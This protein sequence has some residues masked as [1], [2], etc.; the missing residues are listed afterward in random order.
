MR[1]LRDWCDL[2]RRLRPGRK[3]RL[4]I[5]DEIVFHIEE[6]VEGLVESGIPESEARARVLR[7]FG[8]IQG[9][10]DRM[11]A[12]AGTRV[13]RQ[14]RE[15]VMDG[16]WRD[17]KLTARGLARRP[18]FSGV[19]IL[20][21]ALGIGANTAVFS[22]LDSILLRPLPFHEPD[23][24]VR[25]YEE[26]HV[27]DGERVFPNGYLTVPAFFDLREA[28]HLFQEVAAFSA[29]REFGSDL[30]GG[31]RPE[32]V[33]RMPVSS[34]FFHVLGISPQLGRSFTIA[35]ERQGV[36]LA[37]IS[38][39]LWQRHFAGV[40]DV[41]GASLELDGEVFEVIGVMPQGFRG[42]LGR[43]VEVW[44]PA[45]LDP[46]NE[47]NDRGNHFLSAVGRLAPGVTFD[48]VRW[49]IEAYSRSIA[50]EEGRIYDGAYWTTVAIP[51]HE[52]TVGGTRAT[53]WVLMAAVA[54]VLLST[55]V[56][57]ANLFLVR[58]FSRT[59]ELAIRASLGC[60]RGGLIRVLLNE[61]MLLSLLGGGFGLILAWAG[62]QG[63]VRLGPEGLPR[64]GEIGLDPSVLLF[65][66]TVSMAT[67]L[68]LG[69]TPILRASSQDLTRDLR[70]MGR[71]GTG[72]R[73]Y[74]RLRSALVVAEVAVALVLLVGAATLIRSFQ[75]I[76]AVDLK[77]ETEGILTYEV[78]LPTSRYPDGQ[79]REAFYRDFFPRV[80]SLTGVEAVGAISWLPVNGGYNN[81]SVTR[82]DVA[83]DSDYRGMQA[84]IRVVA[85][86]Y[87][88]A[89][90]VDLVSGRY[91]DDKDDPGNRNAV[92]VNELFRDQLFQGEEVLGKLIRVGGQE[93][94][95]VGVVENVPQDAFGET[96][97]KLY[98]PHAQ[99]ADDRNW[100]LTQTLSCRGDQGSLISR[101][102]EE[103]DAVDPNLVLFRVRPLETVL[104][105][106]LVQ[107]RFS[108]LLME[109]F[110][111]LA[112][113]LA[114]VGIYGVLSYLVSQRKHEIGVRIALGAGAGAVR[115]MV[116]KQGLVLSGIGVVLGLGSALYLS[117]WLQVLV[118]EIEV[119]E[120]WMF[121]AVA[122][123]LGGVAGAAS[124]LPARQATRVDPASAFR[125][126]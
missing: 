120:P 89:L 4:D 113:L 39:G 38:H 48:Q 50:E 117:R 114:T 80:A 37:V 26:V 121:C 43:A 3:A 107:Q 98:L 20:T 7:D 70:E 52:D 58:S 31:E 83:E 53:L 126:E 32:R 54:L 69:L 15:D 122:L 67:G 36:G 68:V 81:W 93:W 123:G 49:G 19:V 44:T 47:N 108:L 22:V 35:E 18:G 16:V 27:P 10:R 73:S 12:M 57:V 103:L 29:Y 88:E 110:A 61:T 64:V 1:P 101:L 86:D 95:V 17:I 85:G 79:S 11:S 60:G 78:H 21:L 115:R 41:L 33:V 9:A 63:L 45:S 2:W 91:L 46:A 34:E 119:V 71:T 42:P 97:P 124:Y 24:L 55:C 106:A 28:S 90:A 6:E 104:G 125:E 66:L 84:D 118:F 92:V 30:T 102:R 112:L 25:I 99:F 75:A 77:V 105:A 76:R 62:V 82:P 87:F 8:D 14:R 116:M 56:N 111:G 100:P 65:T 23:R 51:L 109:A 74:S 72:G 59:K 5:D 96:A 13:K 40:R 94:A